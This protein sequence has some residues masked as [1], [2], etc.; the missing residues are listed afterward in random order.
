MSTYYDM[1]ISSSVYVEIESAIIS[2]I[3]ESDDWMET[4]ELVHLLDHWEELKIEAS[5]KI[6][7]EIKQWM[8]QQ[9]LFEKRETNNIFLFHKI[10]DTIKDYVELDI[11]SEFHLICDLAEVFENEI[12]D[13]E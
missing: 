9:K 10:R 12:K 2:A 5:A 4:V 7:Q 11:E 3:K 1:S 8:E 13:N 6:N